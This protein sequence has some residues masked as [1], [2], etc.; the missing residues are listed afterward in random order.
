[1][2]VELLNIL[3]RKV[4]HAA[5]GSRSNGAKNAKVLQGRIA[6]RPM[7][8]HGTE[9][10]V[11]PSYLPDNDVDRQLLTIFTAIGKLNS[12]SEP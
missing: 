10:R 8:S 7:S 2:F 6:S 5:R 1:V 3:G 12:L 4:G 9:S 11:K